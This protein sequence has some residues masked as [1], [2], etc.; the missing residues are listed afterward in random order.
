VPGS[1]STEEVMRETVIL[2]TTAITTHELSTRTSMPKIFATRQE[3]PNNAVSSL[4]ARPSAPRWAIGA[5]RGLG[6]QVL[7]G[8]R[9]AVDGL[10]PGF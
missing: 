2:G 5:D 9:G 10:I 3:V 6:G 7:T 8:R 1:E 4:S